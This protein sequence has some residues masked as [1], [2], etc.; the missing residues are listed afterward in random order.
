M[1][2]WLYPEDPNVA[3]RRTPEPN[4]SQDKRCSFASHDYTGEYGCIFGW[5]F[6]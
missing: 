2:I 4:P 1:F 5:S 3:Q 6:G